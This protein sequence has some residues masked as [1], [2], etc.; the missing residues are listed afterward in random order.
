MTRPLGN[1]RLL[2]VHGY[3]HT[4]FLNPSTCASNSMTAYCNAGVLPPKGTVCGLNLPP[5][6]PPA[7]QRSPHR[8]G[9]GSAAAAAAAS[10]RQPAG[11]PVRQALYQG[12]PEL[13]LPA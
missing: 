2:V 3:V 9:S 8:H 11:V 12:G 1:A 10:R 5:L 6:A 13:T 7:G 4:A